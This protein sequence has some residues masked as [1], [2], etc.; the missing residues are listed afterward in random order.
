V[1]TL[2]GE[3][4]AMELDIND[5]GSL[6]SSMFGELVKKAKSAA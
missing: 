6:Q 4:G 5:D 1:I 3:E 2:I